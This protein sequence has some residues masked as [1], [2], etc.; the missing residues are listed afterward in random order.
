MTID[1]PLTVHKRRGARGTVLNGRFDE[2]S[3]TIAKSESA[4]SDLIKK[5][6]GKSLTRY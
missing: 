5:A 1:R 4:I 6:T 2:P 3:S